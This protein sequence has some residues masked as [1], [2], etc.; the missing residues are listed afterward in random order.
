MGSLAS[1]AKTERLETRLTRSQ[2]KRI[3]EAAR[4]KGTTVS[5]FVAS[6]LEEAASRVLEERH[7]IRLSRKA[8]EDFVKLLLNPPAPNERLLRAARL[9]RDWERRRG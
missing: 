8:A 4:L 6:T 5:E 1:P 2:K 9:H 3:A 7:S